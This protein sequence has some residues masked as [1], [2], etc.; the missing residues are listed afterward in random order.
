MLTE[1]EVSAA[2]L[3]ALRSVSSD[4][5]VK[6]S[7]LTTEG[8]SF[9][10]CLLNLDYRDIPRVVCLSTQLGCPFDCAFCAISQISF[11]RNLTTAEL[12]QQI[13]CALDDVS[14]DGK[15]EPFEVAAMGTGEPMCALPEIIEAVRSAKLFASNLCSLNVATV[16]IPE[17]IRY[18]ARTRIEGVRFNLQLSLHA[19]SDEQRSAI[20]PQ[21]ARIAMRS[22]L[23]ACSEFANLQNTRVLINYLLLRGVN[24]SPGDAV[25]LA[26]L[27]TPRLYAIKV[28]ILNP[29]PGST[30]E[31]ATPAATRE[32]CSMLR[33]EGFQTRIFTSAGTDIGAGCGQFSNSLTD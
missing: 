31:G 2:R 32:F 6:V 13:S 29:T 21:A 26:Q 16:G 15:T 27:L 4:G 1:T 22:I 12:L 7:F 9:E 24:D 25:R 8:V 23:E 28:S 18:Y 10:S 17:R 19:S 11:Q 14:W 5:T 33:R 20:M 30:L 3:P